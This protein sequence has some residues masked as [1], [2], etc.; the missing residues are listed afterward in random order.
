[1]RCTVAIH[2]GRTSTEVICRK[3]T[4]PDG[5]ESTFAKEH[6]VIDWTG[7]IQI[8]QEYAICF[9]LKDRARALGEEDHITMWRGEDR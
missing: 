3:I 8:P 2:D 6:T 4:G 7:Y 1:M 9:R 5:Q